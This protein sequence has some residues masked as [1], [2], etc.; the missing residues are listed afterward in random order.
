MK[1]KVR[2][3]IK[4]MKEKI[5]QRG[6][7]P[8]FLKIDDQF[9]ADR[10]LS[11]KSWCGKNYIPVQEFIRDSVIDACNDLNIEEKYYEKLLGKPSAKTK[12]VG[13]SDR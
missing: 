1:N 4:K 5:N 13:R 12:K 2:E 11:L 8:Y 10:W 9:T 3:K 6:R 7:I